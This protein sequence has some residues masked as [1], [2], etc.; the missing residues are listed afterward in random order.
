[1]FQVT[2]GAGSY[3]DGNVIGRAT[4][5]TLIG[6]NG[7]DGSMGSTAAATKEVTVT[8]GTIASARGRRSSAPA[9]RRRSAPAS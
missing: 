9:S 1:M 4:P 7:V 2:T 3:S 5:Y 6:S 8:I